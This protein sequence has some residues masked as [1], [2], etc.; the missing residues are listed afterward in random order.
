MIKLKINNI[1]IEVAEGT[2]VLK[3]A[4]NIGIKIPTMCF[5]EGFTNH[6]SCMLCLVKD[7]KTG[8]LHPSCALPADNNMEIITDDDEIYEARKESLELLLSDHVGDCEAPCRPSCPAFMDIPLMNRLIAEGKFD[9]ALE[10]VKQEIALPLILGYICPAPCEKAC[11]R[12]QV[13]EAVSICSL[14]RFVAAEDLEN[15]DFHLPQKEAKS[16]KKVAVIGTGP[17][18]LACAFYVLKHGHE[19]VLFDKNEE[20]GGT[21]RYD[22]PEEKLPNLAIDAEID[23]L[24]KFGAEFRLNKLIDKDLFDDEIKG[25][26]DAVVIAMG[27][28]DGSNLEEFGF[29][30]DK[31]GLVINRDTFE[32][33]GQGI[34]ACGNIIRSRRMAVTSV[35]QG[36]VAALSVHQYLNGENPEKKHR[37]F[38]SKFGK[39]FDEEIQEYSKEATS[40][41][42]QIIESEKLDNFTI[43]Q[44]IAEA[45]RCMHCD[46][47]KPDTCKLRIFADEYQA[48]RKKFLYGERKKIKKYFQHDLI[49]YEPEKCIK[50]DLCVEISA[51]E[52]D[53]LGFTNIRRGFDV[54]ISIPFN[55][56]INKIFSNTAE[57]CA[58]ACPTGAISMK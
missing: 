21:L 5:H 14:K 11:R 4:E 34:F 1:S 12:T 57:K 2:S 29:E 28:F 42:R 24:K 7:A 46:C 47:R 35:A 54:E 20:A 6:P 45:K 44:A 23:V 52:K 43:D 41:Q 10:I 40:D 17:A 33:N 25:K 13:D 31:F 39:L 51:L 38:N 37:M 49:V 8:K 53:S 22:I 55:K 16:N 18:G 36:K 56:S 58:V 15:K 48:D 50:C 26:F 30:N 3:A 19:C 27:N 9:E 32:V